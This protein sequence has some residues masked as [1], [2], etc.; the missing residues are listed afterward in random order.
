M[1]AA[2]KFDQTSPFTLGELSVGGRV[3]QILQGRE[4]QGVALATSFEPWM[5]PAHLELPQD[6]PQRR[7]VIA[8]VLQG[9]AGVARDSSV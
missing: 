2:A 8:P 1:L 7:D 3:P 5:K 9:T 4:F 6:H